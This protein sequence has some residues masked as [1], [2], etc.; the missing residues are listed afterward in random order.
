MAE[1]RLADAEK[2][3]NHAIEVYRHVMTLP[4]IHYL[5]RRAA[6]NRAAAIALREL[7]NVEL[8]KTIVAELAKSDKY[9][10][11]EELKLE[12]RKGAKK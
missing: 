1:A 4:K 6:G 7:K 12:I 8:A 10:V 3:W 2:D 9:G 11:N 5:Q